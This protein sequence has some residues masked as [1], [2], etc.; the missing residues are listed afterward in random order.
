MTELGLLPEDWG[1]IALGDI[2]DE[3]DQRVIDAG[4]RDIPV[5]SMTRHTGLILQDEKFEKRVASRDVNKYKVVKKGQIVYGFP[6]DEGVI[7]ALQN[8]EYGA[9][10][11]VYEVWQLES[12]LVSIDFLDRLLR[13]PMMIATYRRL[14]SNTVQRRRIIGK[15]DF[16]DIRVPIPPLP[17]QKKIA[18]VLSTIQKAVEA[19]DKIIAAARELKKSLMRHLFT[20][21]PVPVAEAEKVTLQETEIGPVSEHWQVVALGEVI[22]VGPQNGIYK[23]QSL[24]GD[25]TYILRIDDYGNE[26]SIVE[27][28]SNKVRLSV[29]ETAKYLL[30][31]DDILINRVN[32]LSH[33]G[34]VALIEEMT[35]PMV[36]ESNM[37]RFQVDRAKVEPAFIFRFLASPVARLQMVGKAKRAVAQSSINQGDVRSTICPFPPKSVQSEIVRILDEADAKI[38]SEE[39]RKA[40]LQALFKTMLHHLMTGKVRVKD[41]EVLHELTQ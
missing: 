29:E 28:A 31:K 8:H 1:M 12:D 36:F 37:M 27:R 18:G 39:N 9:V 22:S 20:Y 7:Y 38:E 4:N 33:L 26:G 11:P 25:G 3:V 41:T 2:L 10:S 24:Y 35:Q 32:S 40:S 34:K 6:M 17:E 23:E 14:S 21:G 5:L 19:Q 30:A 13:T 16:R 15:K